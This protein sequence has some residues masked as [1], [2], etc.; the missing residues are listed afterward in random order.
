MDRRSNCPTAM[1]ETALLAI[2]APLTREI[3]EMVNSLRDFVAF[4]TVSGIPKYAGQCNEAAT[5][6]RK[7]FDLFNAETALLSSTEGVNPILFGRF[8][9]S[10]RSRPRK[11][12]L[13]YGHYDVVDAEYNLDGDE[14]SGADP[15]QLHPLNGYLYGRGVTDNKGPILAALYAVAD[16]VQNKAL[17][18]DA[19]FLIEG[20]EEAGSRGFARTVQENRKLIGE[21]DWIL[22]SNSYWLDDHIPCVTYGMRGVIHASIVVSSGLPDRHSGMDGKSTLHEPLKDLTVLLSGLVGDKGINVKVPGFYEH[23]ARVDKAEKKRYDAITSSL[24]PG[25][26]EIKDA[27]A[28]TDSLAQRWREPNLT[29]HRIEVPESKAAVTISRFAK[30]DLSLRIVPN[31]DADTISAALVSFASDLFNR[32]GS[33]NKLDVHISSKA[34]AWLGDPNNEIYR[35]LDQ[36]ITAVWHPAPSSKSARSTYSPSRTFRRPSTASSSKADIAATTATISLPT[37]ST[38]HRPTTRRASSL[39]STGTT[40][41][42]ENMPKR[43]LYIREGGSIP[44]ISFLEKE[45]NAPAAMFPCGQASDNA[46]LDNERMRVQNLYHGREVFRRVFEGLPRD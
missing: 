37:A 41:T 23:V 38:R 5:F 26:P 22:L 20:E 30:A 9:A 19:V 33:T 35:I 46:H 21:I 24:M 44:A 34:N 16:L 6:L 31:Q 36:A 11:T 27:K 43:P 7:L 32:L 15:F 1:V 25:H 10:D 14:E 4:R 8:E 42:P 3:D 29:I 40:Y 12:V 18:C 2:F 28:F 45:F 17:N 39:A 13:F